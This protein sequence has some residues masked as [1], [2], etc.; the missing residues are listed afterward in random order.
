MEQQVVQHL[1]QSEFSNVDIALVVNNKEHMLSI[2][3]RA[4]LLDTLN[5][6]LGLTGSKNGCDQGACGSCTILIDGRRVLACMTLAV[7]QAGKSITTIEGLACGDELHP[8][9]RAFIAY[10]AFQCGYC[11][12]GQIVSAVGLLQEGYTHSDEEIKQFM[13]GNICRCAAYPQIVEAIKQVA[14]K[15]DYAA[16]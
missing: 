7:M 15:N 2:D 9:Q 12:S 1:S 8:M 11:T 13:S 4:T 3:P 5:L 14:R 6:Q 10:D 16:V